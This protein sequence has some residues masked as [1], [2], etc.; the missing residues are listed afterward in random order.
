MVEVNRTCIIPLEHPSSDAHAH[1]Q[2]TQQK[3]QYCQNKTSDYCWP[4]TPKKPSDIET[5]KR[6]VENALYDTL[7]E[8]T[9]HL[10]ANL[11]QKA[12]ADV[13]SALTTLKTNWKNGFRISKPEWN[14]SEDAWTMTYDKRAATF[15]K[16]EVSLATVNGR[17]TL[18]YRLPETLNGTPYEQYV[19]N[20]EWKTTTSKL[21]YRNDQYWLHFGVKREYNGEL[22][23][24]RVDEEI[25]NTPAE[26]TVRV[27]GVDLNVN[28]AS[29]VT[30]TAG[31]HGNADY[32]NHRRTQYEELRAELQQTAT[33]SAYQR[34]HELAHDH[35]NWLKHY[36]WDVINGVV[37][38]ALRVRATHVV[39]EKLDGIRDRMSNFPK[40]Q[41]WMFKRIQDGVEAK[42]EPCGVTV[43]RVNPRNTSKGCSHTECGHVS[44]SNRSGKHF[45]C[46]ECGLTLNADYNAARNIGL[47]FIEDGVPAGRTRS[48]GRAT[49]QLAL[50]SG[51]LSTEEDTSN[52][53]RFSSMD[54]MSTDKPTTSVVGR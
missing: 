8:D 29:A 36:E 7:R 48:S 38:D 37:K 1:F 49:S 16:H 31:F 27:L 44:D 19:L 35:A 26:D 46:D 41:Q 14:T 5:S 17:V 10:H 9:D 22:W 15:H 25:S 45:E 13:T 42:L 33:R 53:V 43:V 28:G 24:T 51:V 50:M 12:I 11:V 6:D 40:F 34:F 2:Q 4:D 23:A 47:R 21:V 30:S 20:P 52:G 39:F 18:Q 32:L 54:W 3:Y